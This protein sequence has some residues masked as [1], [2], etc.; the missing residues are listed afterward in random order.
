MLTA[1]RSVWSQGAGDR[2]WAAPIC[3][4]VCRLHQNRQPAA[5]LPGSALPPG[6]GADDGRHRLLSHNR[7]QVGDNCSHCMTPQIFA[8]VSCMCS[9]YELYVP[10]ALVSCALCTAPGLG[11][12]QAFVSSAVLRAAAGHL[13]PQSPRRARG[14]TSRRCSCATSTC[15]STSRT[16]RCQTRCAFFVRFRNGH[17]SGRCCKGLILQL[18]FTDDCATLVIPL[19]LQHLRDP[20]LSIS[21]RCCWCCLQGYTVPESVEA[22]L[23]DDNRYQRAAHNAHSRDKADCRAASSA[24]TPHNTT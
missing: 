4:H 17:C 3:S 24:L 6:H 2:H 14:T 15:L 13:R 10:L 23:I 22:L 16:C 5:L 19:F 12:E 8:D 20:N 11:S 18:C 21:K 9:R 7:Q 1:G